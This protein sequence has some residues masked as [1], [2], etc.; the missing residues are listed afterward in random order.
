MKAPGVDDGTFRGMQ[1]NETRNKHNA[2][3]APQPAEG[4]GLGH[5]HQK[6]A[7]KPT[8]THT[9]N[10]TTP[11]SQLK[12]LGSVMHIEVAEFDAHWRR[13]GGT[14]FQMPNAFFNPHDFAI[15]AHE[16]VFFQARVCTY[17]IVM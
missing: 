13:T 9:I 15:T 4:A 12:A 14:K 16:Y 5:A 1:T 17:V 8:Q 7:P 2:P 6:R 3:L 10:T 11:R